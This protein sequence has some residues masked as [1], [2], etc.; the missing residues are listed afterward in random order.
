MSSDPLLVAAARVAAHAPSPETAL[1]ELLEIALR[2]TGASRAVAFLW[3]GER[4]G[5]AVAG[6][7]GVA[8][9]EIPSLE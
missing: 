6:S 9:D 4:G 1:D 2:A 3:D 7:R 8:D 5:L